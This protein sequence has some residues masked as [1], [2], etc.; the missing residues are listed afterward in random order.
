MIYEVRRRTKAGTDKHYRTGLHRDACQNEADKLNALY[1]PRYLF[2]VQ[3]RHERPRYRAVFVRMFRVWRD[4][5]GQ[6]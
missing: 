1:Y 4:A 6:S 2:Y 3:P 5:N